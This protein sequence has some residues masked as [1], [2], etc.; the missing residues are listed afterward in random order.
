[1]EVSPLQSCISHSL[2]LHSTARWELFWFP[3]ADE[4]VESAPFPKGNWNLTQEAFDLLLAHLDGDREQAGI[5]YEALRRKLVKFFEWRGC[6]FTEELADDTINRIAR[7]LERGEQIRNFTA[8]CVGIARNVFFESLRIRKREEAFQS[9]PNPSVAR[10]DEQDQRRECL[11]RCLRDLPAP[12][13]RLIVEYYQQD[14]RTRIALRRDLAVRLGIP[15]NALRIRTHR[16]RA[17]LEKCVEQCMQ[18]SE[19]N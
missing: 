2:V 11:E 6:A 16:I 19:T 9:M 18:K 1:M 14:K 12:D 5:K 8:Y 17:H 10:S 15:L 3:G 13:L 4:A 7:N